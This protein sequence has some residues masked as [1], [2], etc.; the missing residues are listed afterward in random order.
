L[1]HKVD[2]WRKNIENPLAAS[3]KSIFTIKVGSNVIGFCTN[4]FQ[5]DGLLEEKG[6]YFEIGAIYLLQEF[7]GRG[8]GLQ[9]MKAAV[10]DLVPRLPD[11]VWQV[12]FM[13]DALACGRSFR[14]FNMVD[15]FNRQALHIKIDTSITA[16]RLARIFEQFKLNRELPQVVRTVIHSL[17]LEANQLT[18]QFTVE[19]RNRRFSL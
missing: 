15:D 12:D 19:I 1:E 10:A 11:T 18:S 6:F 17:W 3:M 8:Y 2:A 16:A 9:L 13:S 7:Q 4:G 5:R 14:T